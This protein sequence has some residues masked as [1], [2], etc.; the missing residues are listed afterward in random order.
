MMLER[1]ESLL[2]VNYYIQAHGSSVYDS[3][4]LCSFIDSI[5]TGIENVRYSYCLD[6]RGIYE[7]LIGE[8]KTLLKDK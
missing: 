4:T 8:I 1:G 6:S 2:D 7:A 3:E 5:I